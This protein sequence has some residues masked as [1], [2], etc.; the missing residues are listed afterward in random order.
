MSYINKALQKAQKEKESQYAAY[1][2]IIFTDAEKAQQPSS[3]RVL[4]EVSIL[5]ILIVGAVVLLYRLIDVKM[6]VAT[7]VSIPVAEPVVDFLS[8]SL[9]A[10][11]PV[12]APSPVQMNI[13]AAFLPPAAP[14]VPENRQLTGKLLPTKNKNDEA[15]KQPS[16]KIVPVAASV[17]EKP[18]AV[19][20]KILLQ[21]AMKKQKEGRLAQAREIYRQI[22]NREPRN[23][24]ALNNL[25]VIYLSQKN[26]RRAALRLNDALA[27]QPNYVDAHYN[28][29][30]LYAQTKEFDRSLQYLKTAARINPE[31][32]NW[33]KKD[34]DLQ[35][36]S[37]F[38]DFN[39]LLAGQEN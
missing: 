30:C 14:A 15:D 13:S 4:A 22:I 23:L 24:Q 37:R 11:G 34:H 9:N 5:I 17:K 26:Y 10:T 39:N 3:R 12:P 31:V 18:E 2:G 21:Q 29:A 28:L 8:P 19:N 7:P 32:R 6:L 27:V 1:S 36:L 35:E 16:A 33:A 38:P 25:G 20:S